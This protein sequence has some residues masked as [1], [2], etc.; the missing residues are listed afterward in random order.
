MKKGIIAGVALLSTLSMAALGAFASNGVPAAHAAQ[1]HQTAKHTAAQLKLQ[2]IYLTIM[3]GTQLGP[4]KKL[5]D[6]YSP[7]DFT[8]VQG[9]PVQVTIYNYD[10]G[11]HSFTSPTFGLNEVIPGSTKTGVP[12]VK[13]FTFTP[14]DTGAFTWRCDLQCDGG[15]GTDFSMWNDGYMVGTVTVV[16]NNH[17]EQFVT[18]TIQGGLDFGPVKKTKHG[19]S[20]MHDAFS[21]ASFTVT[22]G[23][24]VHLMVYNWDTGEHS[25]TSSAL[26]LN[27]MMKGADKAGDF[28]ANNFVF[29]VPKAGK[30]KWACEVKCDGGMTSY[31]MT[32]VGYM[33]GYI[34][35][36]N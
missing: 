5:H 3:P 26:G 6:T 28:K 7:A 35:A 24:P 9:V 30:Y 19:T 1:V 13:T 16:P 17:N 34:N 10:G 18:L 29:T 23:I 25:I 8:V 14:K 4:D 20:T 11:P 32:H 15:S 27:L 21:P 36:T 22:P 31:S 2:H 33:E 12:N